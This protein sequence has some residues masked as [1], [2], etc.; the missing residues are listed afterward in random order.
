[1]K[2]YVFIPYTFV[3]LL[4]SCSK[5]KKAQINIKDRIC[6]QDIVNSSCMVNNKE[7]NVE[8]AFNDVPIPLY[9]KEISAE[10]AY[11]FDE[12]H[13]SIFVYLIEENKE[14]VLLFYKQQMDVFG[15]QLLKIINGVESSFL[16]FETPSR[17]CSIVLQ[18]ETDKEKTIL[19]V[20]TGDKHSFGC[21]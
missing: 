14:K 13:D 11:H 2:H 10:K 5:Q 12:Y 1:M 4:S 21:V 6:E 18:Q 17:F 7:D 20:Y 16:L 3:F 8:Y 19:S 9:L 15:W